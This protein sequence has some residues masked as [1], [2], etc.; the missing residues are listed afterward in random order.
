MPD[1]CEVAKISDIQHMTCCISKTVQAVSNI[2]TS[3]DIDWT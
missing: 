3:D 1:A 2:D